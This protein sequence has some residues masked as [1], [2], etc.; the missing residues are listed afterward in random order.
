MKITYFSSEKKNKDMQPRG[1]Q[2]DVLKKMKGNK[3]NNVEFY[4]QWK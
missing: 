4:I 1:Q 3:D 2:I